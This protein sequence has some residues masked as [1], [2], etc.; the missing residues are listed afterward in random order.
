MLLIIFGV[1]I[2]GVDMSS[3]VHTDSIRKYILILSKGPTQ[4]LGHSTLTAEK[5][6]PINFSKQYKII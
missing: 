3:S 6:Y 1:I 2:V 4:K 5:E